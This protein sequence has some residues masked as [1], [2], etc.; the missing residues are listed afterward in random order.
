[1]TDD[2]T[3]T[4]QTFLFILIKNRP[5]V[6]FDFVFLQSGCLWQ[7]WCLELFYSCCWSGFAGVSVVL[8]PA[9]ATSAA[10]AAPTRAAAPDTVSINTSA[11]EKTAFWGL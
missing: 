1:M 7:R 3:G 4:A 11:G 2:R 5:S 6:V 9:A 8:T 10:R